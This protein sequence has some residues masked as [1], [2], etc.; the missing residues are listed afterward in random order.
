MLTPRWGNLFLER[1]KRA[2]IVACLLGLALLPA[3]AAG[4]QESAVVVA[5]AGDAYYPLAQEIVRAEGLPL[6]H[7]LEEALA[8]APAYVLWVVAPS[9]LSAEVLAGAG[10]ALGEAPA[11]PSLGTPSL[12]IISGATPADARA[13]WQRAGGERGARAIAANAANPQ[14]HIEAGIT[15]VEGDGVATTRPLTKAGL[16]GALQEADYLTFTGHGGPGWLGLEKGV[17]LRSGDVPP[18]GPVAVATGSCNTFHLWEEDSLPLA[19]VAQGAA[20]YAGFLFSP[21]EGYL[22]GEFGGLPWRYTWPAFPIGH[23]VQVQNQ[24]T[25]QGFAQFPYYFLLGDPRLALQAEAPYELVAAE[26]EGAWLELAFA[27]APAGFVP[28]RIPGGADYRFVEIPGVGAAW[29]DGPFYNA[30]LQMANVGADKLLLFEHEGGDFRLRLRNGPPAPWLVGDLVLDALDQVLLYLKQAQEMTLPLAGVLLLVAVWRRWR[31]R[32]TVGAGWAA[33]LLPAGLVGL[34]FAAAHGL[35]AAIRL[36]QVTIT[37]KEV[38]LA[39]TALAATFLLAGCGTL[40]YLE[41]RT[42]RGRAVALLIGSSGALAPGLFGLGA[43]GLANLVVWQ[44]G[45]GTALWNYRLGLLSLIAFGL[46]CA[47]LGAVLRVTG[48]LARRWVGGG[49]FQPLWQ[50]GCEAANRPRDPAAARRTGGAL[51]PKG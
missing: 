31:H 7:S 46:E 17:A 22:V 4:A 51:R 1:F 8:R 12:G 49:L 5:E 18:L 40:F 10:L 50:A 23:A 44:K 38:A 42:W 6:V 16:V 39:P 29:Q 20:A 11:T 41:A 24:G 26:A 43:I 45:L 48:R 15:V 36:E 35:Y 34:G 33:G 37:S 3:G 47:L 25:L 19:L 32:G 21:N 30:R 2:V 27:G 14:G 13:L 9:N 28:V